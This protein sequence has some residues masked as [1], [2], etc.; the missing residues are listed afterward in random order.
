MSHSGVLLEVLCIRDNPLQIRLIRFYYVL[1]TF[2][3]IDGTS[4][5]QS[6]GVA[7]CPCSLLSGAAGVG[8][9]A[10]IPDAYLRHA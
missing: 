8:P 3:E 7:P 4:P 6:L 9:H 10:Y 1:V 2:R 5:V